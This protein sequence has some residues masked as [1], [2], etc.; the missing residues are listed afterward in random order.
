MARKKKR[1]N[2]NLIALNLF[3]VNMSNNLPFFCFKKTSLKTICK[4]TLGRFVSF[5][6]SKQFILVAQFFCSHSRKHGKL[7][8]SNKM[9]VIY[10]A[11]G[12]KYTEQ[13]RMKYSWWSDRNMWLAGGRNTRRRGRD[14]W[15]F[16]CWTQRLLYKE[17][18]KSSSAAKFKPSPFQYKVLTNEHFLPFEF[19][20]YNTMLH[21]HHI[22]MK[23]CGCICVRQRCWLVVQA[24]LPATPI[25]GRALV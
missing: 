21:M 16:C 7:M 24:Q 17:P 11:W 20:A 4:R 1:A 25:I 2:D 5:D 22:D 13:I 14:L 10:L 19:E 23:W 6:C 3:I 12:K 15:L 18:L 8:A 9:Q